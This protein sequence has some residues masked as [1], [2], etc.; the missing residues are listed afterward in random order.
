MCIRKKRDI[1]MK[2]DYA[3]IVL[4]NAE[5]KRRDTRYHVS[6]KDENIVCIEPPGECCLTDDRKMNA[7]KCI[8]DYYKKKDIEVHFSEDGLY[9]TCSK[10]NC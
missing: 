5:L 3:D 2:I 10:S 7:M 4:L 6:Y 9:F 1:D 8:E